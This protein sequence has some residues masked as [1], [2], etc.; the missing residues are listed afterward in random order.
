MTV[1]VY[2][3]TYGT[4]ALISNPPFPRQQRESLNPDIRRIAQ[5]IAPI[6]PG[7]PCLRQRQHEPPA[8]GNVTLARHLVGHARNR[9]AGLRGGHGLRPPHR[10]RQDSAVLHFQQVPAHE[11]LN[12]AVPSLLVL[13]QLT[14]DLDAQVV[15]QEDDQLALAPRA[16]RSRKRPAHAA[17]LLCPE[18]SRIR[19]I[20]E[21]SITSCGGDWRKDPTSHESGKV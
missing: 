14:I 2:V 10:Q 7:I 12:V 18:I 13:L 21:S 17:L 6:G 4:H 11:L 19:S 20:T 5:V 15:A 9:I 8:V 1:S 16:L 3:T